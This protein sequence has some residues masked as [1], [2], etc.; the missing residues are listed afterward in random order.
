MPKL[1]KI[2]TFQLVENY[3]SICT[4]IEELQHVELNALPVYDDKYMKAKIRTYDNNIY[5]NFASLHVAKDGVEC[6]CFTIFSIDFLID[7]ENKYYFEVYL[8]EFIYEI[9]DE[10]TINYLD[11][12]LFDSGFES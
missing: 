1:L 6:A 12:N 9:V 3:K 2:I 10:Q 8:N 5:T 11:D 4:M 7:Y